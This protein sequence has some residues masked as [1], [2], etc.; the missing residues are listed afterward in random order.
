MKCRG[1]L[2]GMCWDDLEE[3]YEVGWFESDR[4]D[5]PLVGRTFTEKIIRML[6]LMFL[7]LS[8]YEKLVFLPSW[9]DCYHTTRMLCETRVDGNG[10]CTNA[11][12]IHRSK[13]GTESSLG[14]LPADLEGVTLAR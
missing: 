5:F 14:C 2:P 8:E 9:S 12:C 4:G 1:R 6:R 13:R 3:E 10:G 11:V 7:K